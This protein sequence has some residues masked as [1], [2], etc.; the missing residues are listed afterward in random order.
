MKNVGQDTS[1]SII[2]DSRTD[3]EN[4]NDQIWQYQFGKIFRKK[5][6]LDA[7]NWSMTNIVPVI[8]IATVDFM[9]KLKKR[10]SENFFCSF[11][12]IF[13]KYRNSYSLS[14]EHQN[15]DDK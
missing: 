4:K 5:H 8:F 6:L 10:R 14:K 3:L 12:L 2:L 1:G 11:N 13:V 9:C 7:S 15:E